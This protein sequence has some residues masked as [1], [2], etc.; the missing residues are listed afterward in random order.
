MARVLIVDDNETMA[1]M[2]SLAIESH[3]HE[4][5]VAHSGAEALDMVAAETHDVVLLD[6][7][8][9]DMDGF[10]TLRRLR[11]LPLGREL[12]VIV[13]TAREEQG[14]EKRVALAGADGFLRKPVDTRTLGDL[15][16]AHKMRSSSE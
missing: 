12:P 9:P 1:K 10:E 13:V 15:I 6:L 5:S 7:M 11:A 14:L 4:T 2:L 3:G 16:T 8:M